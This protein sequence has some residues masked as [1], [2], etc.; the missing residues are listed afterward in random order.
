MLATA[1]AVVLLSGG[2]AFGASAEEA[3]EKKLA[4]RFPSALDLEQALAKAKTLCL[5]DDEGNAFSR[6]IGFVTAVFDT[7]NELECML[8]SFDVNGD[9]SFVTPCTSWVPV[10]K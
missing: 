1:I 3:F 10:R 8:P 5:C 2:A 9:P 4:K 6:E 7:T